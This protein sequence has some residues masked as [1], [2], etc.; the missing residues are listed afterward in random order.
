MKKSIGLLFLAFVFLTVLLIGC[1]P[2]PTPIPS[3]FT[4]SPAPPTVTPFPTSTPFPSATL[5]SIPTDT[6]IATLSPNELSS[7]ANIQTIEFIGKKFEFRFKATDQPVQIYEYYLPNE[8]P[9]DW[10]EL[11]EI[12]VNPVNPSGNKPID[13]AKRLADV[14]KQQNPDGQYALLTDN[15]SDAVILDFLLP[16]STRQGYLEFNAFKYFTDTTSSQV[17]C[18]H[19]AKNIEGIT[20]SRSFDDVLADITITRDEIVSAMAEFNLFSK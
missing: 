11:V 16:T 5:T 18:F 7:V 3:T 17:I 15:N 19:Y 6:P 2:A 20:S 12:Q 1:A 4:P 8:S 9:S 10:F 14:F 13:F